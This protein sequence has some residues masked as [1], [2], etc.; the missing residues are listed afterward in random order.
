M[1][2]LKK[3]WKALWGI[4]VHNGIGKGF[5]IF[6]GKIIFY[7]LEY[8][9]I[10]LLEKL[11]HRIQGNK[12]VLE[13][14]VDFSDNARALY[15]YLISNNYNEKYQIVWCVNQPEKYIKY[16]TKNVKFVKK[17]H[18][19]IKCRTI[20]SYFNLWTAHYIFFTHSMRELKVKNEKQ[21]LINLW[22][23][24]GYKAAKGGSETIVFD[25][26]LVPGEI[27][28]DTKAEF[29]HCDKEKILPLGYP[30][31]DWMLN[32]IEINKRKFMD[33]MKRDSFSDCLEKIVIWMPTFRNS[34]NTTLSDN[35]IKNETGLPILGH[36]EN[37]IEMNAFCRE[38]NIKLVIKRHYLQTVYQ[39]GEQE[40]TNI[41]FVD[42]SDFVQIGVQL[43][44]ILAFTDALITDYSSIA[45][46]YLLLDKPIGFVLEDYEEY[47]KSRGFV[48]ENPLDY[49]P[50][51]K[52]YDQG[53]M[54]IFLN[55]VAKSEDVFLEDRK[56]VAL[57]THCLKKESYCR[58]ILQFFD[59]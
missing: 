34:A 19:S 39:G 30:R 36:L 46:D 51:N 6:G 43:Y 2:K 27:F 33:L 44:E 52:I 50:G 22:H 38:R 8:P 12:I 57:E 1:G 9:C 10:K 23:G 31:Y 18:V 7:V 53:D 55:N 58:E 37:I 11:P 13:S 14:N 21:V 56:R 4:F 24:C 32:P 41:I 35:T 5:L 29:F 25:Y 26:C 54:W 45:I 20:T 28:I 16:H 3:K 59:L 42:D 40:Y 15:E 49:M 48:F 47:S 17:K